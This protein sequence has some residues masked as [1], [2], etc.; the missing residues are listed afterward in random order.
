MYDEFHGRGPIERELSRRG[1]GEF[2]QAMNPYERAQN[3]YDRE[4][5][6]EDAYMRGVDPREESS[7]FEGPPQE[8]VFGMTRDEFRQSLEGDRPTFPPAG[9]YRVPQGAELNRRMSRV[10]APAEDRA[11]FDEVDAMSLEDIRARNSRRIRPSFRDR[12]REVG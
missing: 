1:M 9:D 5:L 12:F 10:D 2:R 11:R 8:R 3:P 4:R 6:I 7:A